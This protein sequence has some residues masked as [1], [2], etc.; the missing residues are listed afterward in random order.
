MISKMDGV[1]K[2]HVFT[3]RAKDSN[4][5]IIQESARS[6]PT[7]QLLVLKAY[8]EVDW[9]QLFKL[10]KLTP[11]GLLDIKWNELYSKWGK[12]VPEDRKSGQKY[13]TE[14]PPASLKKAIAAQAAEAKATRANRSRGGGVTAKKQATTKKQATKKQAT[15]MAKKGASK[16]SRK[17]RATKK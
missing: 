9:R 3:V 15:N 1:K 14:Q 10:Q 8:R 16:T 13:F 2:N 11:P 12:F 4:H 17:K 7:R 5:M 6:Q